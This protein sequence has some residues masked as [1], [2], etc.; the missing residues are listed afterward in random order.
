MTK[1]ELKRLAAAIFIICFLLFLFSY[2]RAAEVQVTWDNLSE[3]QWHCPN[4]NSC[5]DGDI[6][7]AGYKIYVS[8][9]AGG[10]YELIKSIPKGTNI[11]MFSDNEIGK[12]KY[13]VVTAYNPWGE[14]NFSEEIEYLVPN[15]PA[16]DAPSGCNV[17]IVNVT[18]NK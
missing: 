11:C 17:I 10:G 16:P 14:S 6:N 15:P 18:I 9:V 8:N 2:A 3:E 12:I 13:L 7:I 5:P 4:A 1:D